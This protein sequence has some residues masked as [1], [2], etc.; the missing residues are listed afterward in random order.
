MGEEEEVEEE[1]VA[2]VHAYRALKAPSCRLFIN[3]PSLPLGGGQVNLL[4]DWRPVLY[5]VC[6]VGVVDS[7]RN[8]CV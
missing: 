7:R 1:L 5:V 4:T 3:E 6:G 8:E 2:P